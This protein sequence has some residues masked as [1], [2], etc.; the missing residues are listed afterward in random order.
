MSKGISK[1]LDIA[2]KQ[3]WRFEDTDYGDHKGYLFAKYSPAGQDFYFELSL[4]YKDENDTRCYGDILIDQL[5]EYI[6]GFDVSYETY[7]WLDNSGHGRSGAPYD[8][9]DLYNDM[10]SCME[11]MQKLLDEWKS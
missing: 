6:D 2:E 3:G 7:L 9:R 8:M 10:E 11:M 1:L 5:S 4:D